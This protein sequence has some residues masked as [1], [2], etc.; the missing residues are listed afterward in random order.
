MTS[1][2]LAP[3]LCLLCFVLP[4]ELHACKSNP[5]SSRL[6]GLA[7]YDIHIYPYMFGRF[8]YRLRAVYE[9]NIC[10]YTGVGATNYVMANI[11]KSNNVIT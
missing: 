5:P 6:V 4:T 8:V 3:T 9:M 7:K 10:S 2:V 11:C 1:F